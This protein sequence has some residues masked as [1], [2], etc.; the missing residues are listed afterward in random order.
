MV[1]RFNATHSGNLH[2]LCTKRSVKFFKLSNQ[3]NAWDALI[4][5]K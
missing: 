3:S 1:I 5:E 4:G 2:L